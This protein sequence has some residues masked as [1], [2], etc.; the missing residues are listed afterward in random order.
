MRQ[1][2]L[3][4]QLGIS[5]SYLS[6]IYSGQRPCSPELADK[7]SSLNFVNNKANLSF[8]RRKSGVRVSSAPQLDSAIEELSV[9]EL[10]EVLLDDKAKRRLSPSPRMKTEL[11]TGNVLKKCR[12]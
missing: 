8:A 12:L 10:L 6:M 9:R 1:V 3:A 2:E 11:F 7:L 4:K 5:K